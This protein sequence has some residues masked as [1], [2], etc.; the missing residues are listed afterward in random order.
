P[1]ITTT[2]QRANSRIANSLNLYEVASRLDPG[3]ESFSLAWVGYDAP[4]GG[5]MMTE[6]ISPQPA[7]EG[8]RLLVQDITGFHTTRRLQADLPGGAS[9]A[10]NRIFAHSYG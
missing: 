10:L 3:L 9:V 6:T 8:G 7:I 4:S 1:G 2:L 5:K